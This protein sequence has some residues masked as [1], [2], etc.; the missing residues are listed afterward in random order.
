MCVNVQIHYSLL[1]YINIHSVSLNQF[2][3]RQAFIR[4]TFISAFDCSPL[5]TRSLNEYKPISV[6]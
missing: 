6:V 1:G 5:H 4:D 2:A 3:V